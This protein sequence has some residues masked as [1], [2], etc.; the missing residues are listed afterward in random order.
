MFCW[1][2]MS[3]DGEGM[4]LLSYGLF[5]VWCFCFLTFWFLVFAQ[6]GWML[7]GLGGGLL[8]RCGENAG[9]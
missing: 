6:G 9:W 2:G 7:M 1:R 3:G 4:C 8:G 5:G